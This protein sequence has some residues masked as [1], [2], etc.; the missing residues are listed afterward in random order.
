[1]SGFSPVT[2]LFLGLA[3]AVALCLSILVVR[4]DHPDH[5]HTLWYVFSLTLCAVS[6]LFFYIYENSR[7]IQNTPLGEWL[8]RS[9]SLS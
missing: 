5:V 4:R 3:F 9:Q 2:L 6:V 7:A 1:M 8:E